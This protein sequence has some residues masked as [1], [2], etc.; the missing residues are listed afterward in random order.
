MISKY[1]SAPQFLSGIG[2]N[3]DTKPQT[4]YPPFNDTTILLSHP[5]N[6]TGL[7]LAQVVETEVQ[8]P[9]IPIQAITHASTPTPVKD[10]FSTF[11]VLYYLTLS[12]G[13]PGQELTVDIDTGS[14]DLWIPVK[15]QTCANSQFSSDYSSTYRNSGRR[16]SVSYVR[17][18]KPPSLLANALR[19]CRAQA[20]F[21][22]RSLRMTFQ[23]AI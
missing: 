7:S 13:T 10:F 17:L 4:G 19:V 23:L 3:A 18:N 12:V 2:L 8:S 21:L 1:A 9:D 16:S 15:C 5:T 22:A 6:T 11:D 14:S 20:G